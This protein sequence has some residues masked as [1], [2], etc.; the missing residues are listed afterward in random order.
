MQTLMNLMT[1]VN[2]KIFHNGFTH[3][4][5][6]RS[7]PS[8]TI[9][10]QHFKPAWNSTPWRNAFFERFDKCARRNPLYSGCS[11][12]VGSHFKSYHQSTYVHGCSHASGYFIPSSV[13]LECLV[14][15][16]NATTFVK[17]CSAAP[18]LCLWPFRLRCADMP[19]LR[20]RPAINV[21]DG[22]WSA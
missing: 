16:K 5:P 7:Q 2:P 11:I 4:N 22:R 3:T 20:S 13:M 8:A 10:L 9:L 1:L 21:Y 14:S 15:R 6:A 17:C 12:V 18:S 19:L